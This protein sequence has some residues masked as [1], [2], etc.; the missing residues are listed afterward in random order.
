VLED[1]DNG[2]S[3]HNTVE[4]GETVCPAGFSLPVEVGDL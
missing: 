3:L 2:P 1:E 4:I